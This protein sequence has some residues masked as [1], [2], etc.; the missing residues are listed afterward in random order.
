MLEVFLF[1][2]YNEN[3]KL[4]EINLKRVCCAFLLCCKQKVTF[5]NKT[6]KHVIETTS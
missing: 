2:K 4:S 6:N 3:T 5:F 1:T